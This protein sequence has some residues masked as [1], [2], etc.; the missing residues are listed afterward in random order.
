MNAR[1]RQRGSLF[2]ISISLIAAGLLIGS[3]LFVIRGYAD[4]ADH[5]IGYL[6]VMAIVYS[7][8]ALVSAGVVVGAF[9]VLRCACQRMT[10]HKADRDAAAQDSPP[11][12]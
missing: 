2:W 11:D 3:L 7:G 9:G 8:F 4:Q 5:A 10:S 12:A 1:R 6:G